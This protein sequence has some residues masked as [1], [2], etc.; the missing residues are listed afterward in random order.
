LIK[1]NKQKRNSTTNPIIRAFEDS[2]IVIPKKMSF[3]ILGEK[4]KRIKKYNEII[5]QDKNNKSFIFIKASPNILGD[6]TRKA[7]AISE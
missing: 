6:R 2:A 7:T 1:R 5:N 3:L 4:T